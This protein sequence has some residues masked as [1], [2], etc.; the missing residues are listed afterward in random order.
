MKHL[1]WAVFALA[2]AQACGDGKHQVADRATAT[3]D[4]QD[5]VEKNALLRTGALKGTRYQLNIALTS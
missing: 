4:L 2:L 5:L 3:R 1:P